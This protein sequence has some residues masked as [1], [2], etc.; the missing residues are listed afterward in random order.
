VTTRTFLPLGFLLLA[1]SSLALRPQADVRMIDASFH[2][3]GDD[4]TPEW[5]EASADPEGTRL[6][7]TFQATANE[8]EYTLLVVQRHVSN[9]WRLELNGKVFGT[10]ARHDDQREQP[11]PVPAG[12]LITGANVLSLIPDVPE[13]DITFGNIRLVERPFREFAGLERVHVRVTD[14][15][16]G[17]PVP[18]RLTIVDEA[19]TLAPIFYAKTPLTAV[20]DGVVYTATGEASFEVVRGGYR[21]YATR[22]S[23][24]G[25]AEAEITVAAG[26]VAEV[27]LSIRR[28]VDTTGF[29]A[30]DTHIHTL[31]F[32]GHGDSSVEERMVTLAGEGVELAIA[33]DHNHNTDYRPVQAQLA[34][35]EFFTPVTGNEVTTP[36]GHFNAFPLDPA[37]PVPAYDLKD[38][39]KLVAGMRSK[40]AEVVILNHPRWPS[41][42]EGPFGVIGLD[43]FTGERRIPTLLT[44]DAIELVNSDTEELDPL[45]L[46]HD[47]FALLNRG[48]T[49][50]AVGSSDSHTVGSPVGQGRTYIPSATDDPAAID[51]Q[52]AFKNIKTGRTSIGMGIFADVTVDGIF[53]MG[54]LVPVVD[55]TI[56]VSL[57]IAAP[58]WVTPEQVL[59]F[60]D[61]VQVSEASV[62]TTE[63]LPTDIRLEYPMK[64]DGGHDAWLVCVV[65]GPGISAPYWKTLNNY[66]L[67]ATNPVFLDVDGDGLYTSPRATAQALLDAAGGGSVERALTDCD[68]GVAVQ[69]LHLVREVYL[70]EAREKLMQLGDLAADRHPDVRRYLESLEHR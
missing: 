49:I 43:R 11:Y 55:R 39:V 7:L 30:C 57:R 44:V 50:C 42:E 33:T 27:E 68:G 5:P 34:L 15:D 28:E 61:G 62:P 69:L 25:L 59:L 65:I 18:V 31:T 10:L 9:T 35:G 4:A 8:V 51:L 29:I 36:V 20:R 47:W 70:A 1:A 46:F 48:E 32:S 14:E 58:S 23:E 53:T 24:W 6:D 56:E 12:F 13:D 21:I 22:G 17:G 41:H 54:D 52:S 40:G 3:L 19:G 45:F 38:V 2:H 64:L 26:Q 66:T 67:A 63:G 60:I 16:S 37:E